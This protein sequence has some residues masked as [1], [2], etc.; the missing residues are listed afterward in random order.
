MPTGFSEFVL[1][2]HILI[3]DRRAR[4]ESKIVTQHLFSGKTPVGCFMDIGDGLMASSPEF[5]FLQMAARL[6]LVDLIELGYELCGGYS[7]PLVNDSNVP[8]EGFYDREPLTDIKKLVEFLDIMPGTKGVDKATNAIR[9]V[10]AGSASP[11][12][13]KLAI[14]LSMPLMLGGFGF[15]LPEL[16]KRINLSKN[17]SKVFGKDYYV[18]DIYWADKKTAVEYDSDQQHTGSDRI[19]KDSIRRNTLASSGIK[20][21][22]V[23]KQQLYSSIELTRAAQAIAK[24]MG[25]RLFSRKGNFHNKYLELRKQL[26]K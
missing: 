20:V 23:T 11:M 21:I 13:T 1:P 12:E 4:F 15:D 25:R 6:S 24:H 19:A 5:C 16:N 2:V 7:L 26:L 10:C 9:F 14:F 22:T 18:C 8:K 3:G 17:A